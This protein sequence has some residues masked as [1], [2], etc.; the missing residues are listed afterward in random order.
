MENVTIAQQQ[1]NF[2]KRMGN[3]IKRGPSTSFLYEV[4]KLPQVKIN[5]LHDILAAEEKLLRDDH[6][7]LEEAIRASEEC[8]G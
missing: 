1:A 3:R 7:S 6:V 4:G 5:K 8:Y 2:D